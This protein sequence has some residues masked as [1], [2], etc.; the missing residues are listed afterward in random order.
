MPPSP[1]FNHSSAILNLYYVFRSILSNKDF[2]F[3]SEVDVMLDFEHT[4]R[5]DFKIISD[6]SKIIDGKKVKGAPDFIAEVLS[7]SN[8]SHDLVY[9]RDLYEK[10]GVK[11]YW[12]VDI[13]TKN[14]HVYVLKGGAYGNPEIYH[15]F[16]D[17][18]IE[19]IVNGYDDADKE[20]IKITEIITHTFGGEIRVPINKIFENII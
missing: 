10:H 14:I 1:S 11:E 3:G 5:P 19:E 6:A 20:Q 13:Y 18:E 4:V 15:Y 7:P 9:K 2:K 17:E 12:V 16:T 8:S